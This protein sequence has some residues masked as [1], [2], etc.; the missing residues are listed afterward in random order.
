MSEYSISMVKIDERD[1]T[2]KVTFKEIVTR[3]GDVNAD[4]LVEVICAVRPDLSRLEVTTSVWGTLDMYLDCMAGMETLEETDVNPAGWIEAPE[5][6]LLEKLCKYSMEGLALM[7]VSLCSWAIKTYGLPSET[8]LAVKDLM[9][10]ALLKF[11]FVP[12]GNDMPAPVV[13]EMVKDRFDFRTQGSCTW[14]EAHG[15]PL[16]ERYKWVLGLSDEERE[17]YRKLQE[18]V[19]SGVDPEKA[20]K[21][22]GYAE[23]VG[24]LRELSEAVKD[25]PPDDK[26]KLH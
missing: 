14:M 16:S 20:V 2:R 18:K 13:M 25:L 26:S 22:S 9:T 17:E 6:S 4:M 1:L 23:G 15:H 8:T 11:L 5:G 19:D 7:G 10:K 24:S 12:L 21:E 3:L